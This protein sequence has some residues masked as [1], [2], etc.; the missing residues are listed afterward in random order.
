MGRQM[1]V[2]ATSTMQRRFVVRLDV[3][4]KHELKDCSFGT[5]GG[6]LLKVE[7]EDCENTNVEI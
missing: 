5:T 1:Q 2:K 4:K 3:R 7:I 6:F